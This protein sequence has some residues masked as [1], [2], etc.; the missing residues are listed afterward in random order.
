MKNLRIPAAGLILVPVFLSLCQPLSGQVSS[1]LALTSSPNP[2]VFGGA[3]T[4]TATVTPA[5]ATGKVTFYDGVTVLG[6][7]TLASG[8]AALTT[9][10]LSPG[11]RKLRARYLGDSNTLPSQSNIATQA[12]RT[13]G[14]GAF[15]W[16][17]GQMI[18]STSGIA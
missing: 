13:V 15:K 3:I 11:N 6:T 1:S 14:A 18:L 2:S 5:N 10:L 12:V 16:S 8:T 7:S 9:H 4:L 17:D